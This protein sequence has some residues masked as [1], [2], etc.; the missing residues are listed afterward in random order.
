MVMQRPLSF[1]FLQAG[2]ISSPGENSTV[3]ACI[4]AL[5]HKTRARTPDTATPIIS[6]HRLSAHSVVYQNT[7]DKKKMCLFLK[8]KCFVF[9]VVYV[10]PQTRC[11][12]VHEI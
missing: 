12:V 10:F 5:E 7:L 6:Q 1:S 11:L 8:L 3:S 4:R 2:D 9:F